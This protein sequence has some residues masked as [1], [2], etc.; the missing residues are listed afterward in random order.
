MNS[1]VYMFERI[2]TLHITLDLSA[3]ELASKKH[4]RVYYARASE[5]VGR[6][7]LLKCGKTKLMKISISLS[8][9]NKPHPSI[10]SI[11]MFPPIFWPTVLI[12]PDVQMRF[13]GV[14]SIDAHRQ[15]QRIEGDGSP[16]QLYWMSPGIQST[17]ERVVEMRRGF[18]VTR[19]LLFHPSRSPPTAPLYLPHITRSWLPRDNQA[20]G[21]LLQGVFAI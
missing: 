7:C 15:L 6:L 5:L 11:D 14:S 16:W 8:T 3:P 20:V 1:L 12:N 21:A 9:P 2:R 18:D 4:D 17:P 13:E 19:E 10:T